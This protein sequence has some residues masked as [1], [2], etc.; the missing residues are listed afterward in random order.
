MFRPGAIVTGG[1]MKRQ[2]LYHLREELWL[3]G[4][5]GIEPGGMGPLWLKAYATQEESFW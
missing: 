2:A 3:D 5:L 1:N 4:Y